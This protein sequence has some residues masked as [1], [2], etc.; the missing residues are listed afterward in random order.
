MAI[1]NGVAA[2]LVFVL[3]SCRRQNTPPPPD[4]NG[5]HP[6]TT[7]PMTVKYGNRVSLCDTYCTRAIA[8]CASMAADLALSIVQ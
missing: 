5:I 8:R 3:S 7:E 1:L 6:S 2:M 4:S